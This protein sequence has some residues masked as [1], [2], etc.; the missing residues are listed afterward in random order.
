MSDSSEREYKVSSADA[1]VTWYNRIVATCSTGTMCY[2]FT[3]EV[4]ESTE[5][6]F[7]DKI[8]SFEVIAAYEITV[9]ARLTVLL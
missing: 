5:Y 4:D 3:D 8:I 2:E 7:F 6:L 9:G 1:F